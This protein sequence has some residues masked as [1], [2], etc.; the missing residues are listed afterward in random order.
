MYRARFLVLT[1]CLLCS[2]FVDS[3][4]SQ[5]LGPAPAAT[6]GAAPP[7]SSSSGKPR[8]QSP[9]V[10]S[11]LFVDPTYKVALG[12]VDVASL[13]TD[14]AQRAATD[15][16]KVLRIGIQRGV[17]VDAT[18]G[19]WYSHAQGVSW[20]VDIVAAGA[21]SLRLRLADVQLPPGA[22]IFTYDPQ[23]PTRTNSYGEQV[24]RPGESRWTGSV[25]GERTRF[26]YFVPAGVAHDP[27]VLPF[28]I[29]ELVHQYRDLT[30]PVA[31]APFGAG[32]CHNDVS[33][34]AAWSNIAKATA[35]MQFID[36]GSFVCT[37]TLIQ[38]LASDFTPYFLSANHC[39]STQAVAQT[40]E[41]YWL[42]QTATCGGTP[43]S[44]FSVPRSD[45]GTLLATSSLSDF[46]LFIIEGELPTGLFWSGWSANPVII[47][48]SC[49]SVHHPAGD[50]KRISFGHTVV[51]AA[52]F[53]TVDWDN[54]PTEGGSSGSGIFLNG[55]QQLVGQLCCGNSACGSLVEDEYGAFATNYWWLQPFLVEGRDDLLEDNDSCVTARVVT[56]G[57]Y[58]DLV[59]KSLD[60]DWYAVAVA[61]GAQLQVNLTFVDVNGDIDVELFGSCGSTLLA[62]AA[63][64]N[65]NEGLF[66]TN[67]G[68]ASTFL[69][70]VFLD[71]DLRNDYSMTIVGGAAAPA[72][73]DCATPFVVT[74]GST[75]FTTVGA[76]TDGPDEPGAC[77]F[78]GYTH[79]EADTW[80]TYTATTTGRVAV[81]LCGSTFDTKLAVYDGLGCPVSAPIVCNDDACGGTAQSRAV[82]S[83]LEG[84]TFTIRVGGRF[85]ATGTGAIAISV[86]SPNACVAAL[87][88][89]DGVTAFD[90]TLA[91][92]DGPTECSVFGYSQV[93]NDVWFRYV[94]SCTGQLSISLCGSDYD[95]KLAVYSGFVC[96]TAPSAI[97]CNED[98]CPLGAFQSGVTIATVAGSEYLIRIGGY[99]GDSGTGLLNI[100]CAPNNDSCGGA[101]P[102]GA[103]TLQST[104]LGA[105]R[106]GNADCGFSQNSPDVWYTY[107]APMSGTVTIDTCG[108]NDLGG[109]DAGMDTVLSIYSACPGTLAAQLQCNDEWTTSANPTACMATSAGVPGDSLIQHSMNAGET[110]LIRVAA[111]GNSITGPF[112]LHVNLG[113]GTNSDFVRG[114]CNGDNT[115]NIADAVFLLGILFPSGTP[116][117]P[118][119][120]DACDAN[121]D[122]GNDIADAVRILNALFGSPADP[123]PAP[124]PTCGPDPAG[125][126]LTCDSY[127]HCP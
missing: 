124:Y 53:V 112:L 51:G 72:N 57:T 120:E 46:S 55:T 32:P 83:A 121:N 24:F 5:Q 47:G 9:T 16:H 100:T 38:S 36:N 71:S 15:P 12:P 44:V 90:T 17:Q 29:V 18:D 89:A 61:A 98:N 58:D 22:S 122:E 49:T 3:A 30:Q 80:F 19:R 96:P 60:E 107:T 43:P 33:C 109:V 34:F 21:H 93:G 126:N 117:V 99:Q 7:V 70:R 77:S 25:P 101:T 40:L 8:E 63:T 86:T 85:G 13:Y 67:T 14:D 118:G 125:T 27:L 82:F 73:D 119:C 41:C 113:T 10:A 11:G 56:S 75:A 31:A 50:Y 81:A 92:T 4:S 35:H 87:E 91:T 78:S 105:T 59:V 115:V 79:I 84:E 74:D 108:T 42:Y 45:V 20:C 26:E 66:Y 127:S 106:D 54:G 103:G 64:N 88:V 52:D 123:P 94:S 2:A 39:I 65:N 68:A 1:A 37:G 102:I 6:L 28:A 76:T 69:V 97:A 104:L 111:F 95:T 48:A 114:D 116:N 23:G 62:T 110:I